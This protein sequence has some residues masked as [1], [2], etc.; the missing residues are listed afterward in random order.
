VVREVVGPGP[1]PHLLHPEWAERFPWLLQGTTLRAEPEFDLRL[2]GDLPSGAVLGRLELLQEAMGVEGMV[3]ARQI[4]GR[5]IHLHD[6]AH[7][8]VRL[9][10]PAD[11]HL[12]RVPGLLLLVGAADC[13]PVSLVHSGA[14][15]VAL[16]HA[17]WRGVAEGIL[18]AALDAARDRF[19]LEPDGFSLHL[20]P[21]I[22]GGC[23]EVGPEV[24][25][26]LG[27]PDPGGAALLDL[28]SVLAGRARSL[29]IAAERITHSAHCTR[30]GP[31][32]LYSHRAGQQGRQM[33]F[34]GIRSGSE[35]GA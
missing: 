26:A 9:A 20:G 22:C 2:F 7:D 6:H 4:H 10:A 24:H 25:R 3:H 16:L 32:P 21:A 35:G 30:C 27:L 29:G 13:T 28:R 23:Y 15:V 31:A 18:E 8:G 12:T 1:V 33:G 19:G 17:G 11:G 34:L 5:R 14:R